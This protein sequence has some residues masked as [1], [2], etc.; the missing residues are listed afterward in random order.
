[1]CRKEW[2][3]LKFSS[4]SFFNYNNTI[5]SDIPEEQLTKSNLIV[6]LDPCEIS[7]NKEYI[8]SILNKSNDCLLLDMVDLP[9]T[10]DEFKNKYNKKSIRDVNL[11]MG[12]DCD[13]DILPNK[14]Q[15]EKIYNFIMEHY[16]EPFIVS[17]SAGVSRS[18]ALAHFLTYIGY[19][20]DSI[21]NQKFIPNPLILNELLLLANNHKFKN[22]HL[23]KTIKESEEELVIKINNQ[24]YKYRKYTDEGFTIYMGR[25]LSNDNHFKEPIFINNIY[26]FG[27][28]GLK[29]LNKSKL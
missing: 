20:L 10:S 15:I 28:S 11:S 12:Y 13:Y 7:K 9:L 29:I 1:M 3:S 21:S 18:G 17:C 24:Q 4:V 19:E 5:I 6:C 25:S 8:Y 27:G 22:K 16:G 26:L 23:V 2:V 14:F